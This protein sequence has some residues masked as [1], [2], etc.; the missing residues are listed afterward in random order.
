MIDGMRIG[1][2]GCGNWGRHILRDLRSLDC[3]VPVV[4]RSAASIERATEGGASVIVATAA[5]L[6]DVDGVVIATPT[7]AHHESVR[8]V[9]RLGVP[10]FVEKPLCDDPAAAVRLADDGR[11][12]VFV[13]DKWRYH[14]GVRELAAIAADGRLGPVRGLRTSRLG[15][16]RSHDDVDA[17]WVLAPHD[18]SIAL[19][20]LGRIPPPVAAVGQTCERGFVSIQGL[21]ADEE[22]WLTIDLSERSVRRERRLELHCDDGVA[23]LA[24]GWESEIT[25]TRADGGPEPVAEHVQ[26]PGELP[27]LAELRAFLAHLRGGPAPRSSVDEGAL[28]VWTIA[29]LRELA[30]GV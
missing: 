29:R 15:W 3:V 19:E 26:T 6:G 28:V 10:I 14:P 16:G 22:G 2:V 24:G 18:L 25:I 21:L 23:V 12:R 4:A 7:S 20:V 11:G 5:E 30:G 27:L 8:E 9:L 13:M 1:L 17:T